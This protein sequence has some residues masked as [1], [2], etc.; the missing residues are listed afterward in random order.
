MAM[1]LTDQGLAVGRPDPAPLR[2]AEG[3][4]QPLVEPAGGGVVPLRVEH[5]QRDAQLPGELLGNG[6]QAGAD[7]LPAISLRD[8]HVVQIHEVRPLPVDLHGQVGDDRARLLGHADPVFP[9]GEE[10]VQLV[11][12]V[13][14]DPVGVIDGAQHFQK[15]GLDAAP[16]GG[17]GPAEPGCHQRWMYIL[18]R[19]GSPSPWTRQRNSQPYC[20]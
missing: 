1:P 8:G 7:A 4:A 18:V 12:A 20:S 15:E 6:Q 17:D 9:A 19:S 10:A 14:R 5:Q 16:V 11:L 13:A 2:P 3:I